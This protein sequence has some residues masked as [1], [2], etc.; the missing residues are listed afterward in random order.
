MCVKTFQIGRD[1]P[2]NDKVLNIFNH[3]CQCNERLCIYLVEWLSTRVTVL[4]ENPE[5]VHVRWTAKRG[6]EIDLI[7]QLN[8]A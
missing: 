2:S 5:R 8:V 4:N 1:N 6:K 7:G 3:P